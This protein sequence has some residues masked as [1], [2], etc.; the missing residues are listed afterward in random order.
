MPSDKGFGNAR[1]KGK[2]KHGVTYDLRP[3]RAA[4]KAKRQ[5]ERL[6]KKET[7][8]SMPGTTGL[9]RRLNYKGAKARARKA[10]KAAVKKASSVTPEQRKAKQT[11]ATSAHS[12]RLAD[13]TAKY[14]GEKKPTTTKRGTGKTYDQAWEQSSAAYKKEYGG[15]KAKAI[16][17]MKDWNKKNVDKPSE[18]STSKAQ[19]RRTS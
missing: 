17:A 6:A 18:Y 11:K 8:A 1:N 14:G 4:R 10:D 3:G 5:A 12:K 19:G 2:L 7:I 16:A 15:D 9:E 13:A